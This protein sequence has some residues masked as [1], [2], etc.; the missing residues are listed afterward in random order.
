MKSLS[1]YGFQENYYEPLITFYFPKL[2]VNLK[3]PSFDFIIHL[4]RLE[5]KG[6][7]DMKVRVV[8]VDLAGKG[9]IVGVL[10]KFL[11]TRCKGR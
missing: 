11:L 7:Y 10:G 8:L 2:R 3:E 4:P 1:K 9:D 5:F 6:K